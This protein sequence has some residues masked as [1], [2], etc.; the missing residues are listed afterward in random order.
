MNYNEALCYVHQIPRFVRPLGLEKL[1]GLLGLLENPQNDLKYVHIAGT[2]GKGSTSAMTAEILMRAGLR[3]GL[4]TSPFIEVFNERIRINGRMIDDDTLAHYITRVAEV[5]EEND[6][7]VSEFAF[8]TA[9][10]FCY[11]RD[12]E[13]DIVVLEVGMGGKLDATNIIPAPECSVIT[14]IGFDHTEYLGDTLEEIAKEKCGII[15][16]GSCV[17]SAPNSAVQTTIRECAKA[18]GEDVV[19]CATAEKTPTGAI[20]KGIEY[21]L[22]LKGSYQ[23]ENMAVAIEVINSL[24]RRG[25]DIPCEALRE[26]LENTQWMAR[27]EFVTPDIVIDGGHNLDGVNALYESL[28]KEGREITLVLAMCADKDHNECVK[29]LVPVAKQVI[30]T[31]AKIPRALSAEELMAECEAVG[32]R[33]E[34]IVDI[35]TAIEKAVAISNGGL[36]CI[37]GSLYLAGE[38]RGLIREMHKAE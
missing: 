23:A 20:Y 27:Y 26:G 7:G 18:V 13:C 21:A 31:E 4:F 16:T 5:M 35:K 2:N 1:S 33:C 19:F 12:M 30:T 29:K 3:V 37:C 8:I 24:G 17:V 6:M 9:V 36:V 11:F 25:Y 32:V 15:K 28:I 34:A 22:G 38:A 14:S 10:A